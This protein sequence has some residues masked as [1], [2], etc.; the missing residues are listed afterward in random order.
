MCRKSRCMKRR[1]ISQMAPGKLDA[2]GTATDDDEIQRRMRSPLQHLALRQLK[3][4]QNPPPNL[5]RVFHGLE[6]RRKRLPFVVAEVGVRRARRQHQVVVLHLGAA[7]KT[8]PP[9]AQI[10]ADRLIHQNFG[11]GLPRS[12]VRSGDAMSAGRKHRQRP[13]DTAAAET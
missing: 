5:D 3:G 12:M 1:V 8:H 13:P 2:R 9:I 11:V 6:P 4:Q 7:A 10:E